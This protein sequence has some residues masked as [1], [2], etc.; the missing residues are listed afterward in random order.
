MERNTLPR[1]KHRNLRTFSIQRTHQ[2]W[3]PLFY[4]PVV[5]EFDG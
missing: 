3:W 2:I 1:G 5:P 4:T